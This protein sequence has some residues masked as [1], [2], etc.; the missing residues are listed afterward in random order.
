LAS[1]GSPELENYK[2]A[3]IICDKKTKDK[4]DDNISIVKWN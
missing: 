3:I 2:K 1:V 4:E